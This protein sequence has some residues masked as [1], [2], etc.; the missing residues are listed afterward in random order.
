[1]SRF[2]H[3][4]LTALLLAV[5]LADSVVP[6]SRGTEVNNTVPAL[7][8]GPDSASKSLDKERSVEPHPP[9]AVPPSYAETILNAETSLELRGALAAYRRHIDHELLLGHL[10]LIRESVVAFGL[11]AAAFGLTF[12][13]WREIRGRRLVIEPFDVPPDFDA[14]GWAG[15]V[16]AR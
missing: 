5:L 2:G 1:M 4:I 6:A 9:L 11:L 13:I 12:L 3:V 10:S 7:S 14:R 16:V 15:R 8:P